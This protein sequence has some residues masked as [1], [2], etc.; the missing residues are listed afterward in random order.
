MTP[1]DFAPDAVL[2]DMDGLMIESER[3]L[4][5]CWREASRGLGLEQLD[6]AL[7]LSFVGLSDRVCADLLRERLDE[8]QVQALLQE[9]QDRYDRHVDAGLPLKAGVLELLAELGRR[10]IP[11]AVVTSTRRE[12]A[13]QKLE[14]CGLLPHF[15]T[16]VTG[17]DVANPKPAPDIYLLAAERLRVS[18][19]R[20]VVL[21]DS[22]P[23]VRAALA[24]GMTPIQ[25][26][27]LVVPDETARALGHRIV[28]S[29]VHAR[30]LIAAAL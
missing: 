26:P 15:D 16:V 8:A 22:V 2:F 28:D 23:G 13:L 20:C 29:L 7:W 18:P 5:Q 1:V 14:R 12:R 19:A 27:D 4:L 30:E 10:N 9:T 25:V 17:S 21:E 3:A 24:A 11:R 6:D